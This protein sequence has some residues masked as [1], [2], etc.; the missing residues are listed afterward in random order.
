MLN[1]NFQVTQT[2]LPLK[3]PF[4]PEQIADV[5]LRFSRDASE[6]FLNEARSYVKTRLTSW[7]P[8]DSLKAQFPILENKALFIQTYA[9]SLG[10]VFDDEAM[11]ADMKLD[12]DQLKSHGIELPLLM[13]I[14]YGSSSVPMAVC[15]RALQYQF[16]L[17]AKRVQTQFKALIEE[18][19]HGT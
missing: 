5:W 17:F 14:E 15:W 6:E 16:K 4:T 1:L 9:E 7:T 10:C 11:T 2:G 18:A 19:V 12:W 13:A 3:A 8:P